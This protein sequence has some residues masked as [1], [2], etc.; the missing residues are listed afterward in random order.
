MAAIAKPSISRVWRLAL[1]TADMAGATAFFEQAFDAVVLQRDVSDDGLGPLMGLPEARIAK[2]RV[3]IGDEQIALLSFDPPGRPYPRD[4]TSSDLWFQHFAIIVSDMAA[5]YA[6]LEKVGRFT[7]ISEGGP[8]MLP[9]ASGSVKAFKFRDAEGHPLELLEFPPGGGPK[10]WQAKRSS[11]LFLG[12]DHS[13]VAVGDTAR[14]IAFLEQGFGLKRVMQT[15]N[16]GVEQSRMDAVANARVSV[17]GLEPAHAPPHVELLGYHV[18]SRRPIDDATRSNDIAATHF[19]MQTDNLAAIVEALTAAGAR[20]V[21][22][23]VVTLADGSPAILVLDPDGH[24]FVVIEAP[25]S[26]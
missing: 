6:R 13:A 16:Q 23:G 11:G 9:P 3:A 1:V 10:I 18:G 2:T 14:S 17:S 22:P 20:F 26:A 19:V 21:S 5:A 24:R 15:E 7:P 4:G 8:Q 12:I 25:A